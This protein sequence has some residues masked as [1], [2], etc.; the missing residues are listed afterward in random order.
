MTSM[1]YRP[2]FIF[3]WSGYYH[4]LISLYKSLGLI[5]Q[6]ADFSYSFSSLFSSTNRITATMVYNGNSGRA[7]FSKPSSFGGSNKDPD[8]LASTLQRLWVAVLFICSTAQLVLCHIITIFHAIPIW[9]STNISNTVFRDWA[10]QAK[11]RG[12][13]AKFCGM[14]TAWQDYI[15]SV[16]LPLLSVVCTAPEAVIMNH[17]MEEILGTFYEPIKSCTKI[18]E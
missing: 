13:L 7:G 10:V 6:Q 18:H 9:R 14:D 5:F 11:P 1:S 12:F 4:H 8:A 15:R 2:I 16:L 17:P 3:F